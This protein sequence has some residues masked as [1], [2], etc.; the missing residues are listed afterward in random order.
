[1]FVD[2][3]TAAKISFNYESYPTELI[4]NFHPSQLEKR[5]GG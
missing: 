2:K 5:F 3:E 4:N 1:M